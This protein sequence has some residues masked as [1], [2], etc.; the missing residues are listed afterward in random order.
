MGYENTI[1][2]TAFSG[3]FVKVHFGVCYATAYY[4]YR[5]SDVRDGERVG[6]KTHPANALRT[7]GKSVFCAVEYCS[8]FA[9]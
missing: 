6:G 1:D 4:R 5:V 3:I 7:T 8:P 9:R 2:T